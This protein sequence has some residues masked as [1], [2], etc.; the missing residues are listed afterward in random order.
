MLDEAWHTFI[1]FTH[2]Y[3]EF[4][5]DYLGQY[6]HHQPNAG[7]H[8]EAHGDLTP[9]LRQ[10]MEYVY[11]QLGRDTLIKWY[12]DYHDKYA[13]LTVRFTML[14]PGEQAVRPHES[15]VS[16]AHALLVRD[17]GPPDQN[18]ACNGGRRPVGF[19]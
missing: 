9:M 5:R 13:G 8:A 1:L 14:R 17:A 15:G 10:M 19:R 11:D 7:Q 6:I 18:S 12:S 2:D 16:A 3:L 4:C